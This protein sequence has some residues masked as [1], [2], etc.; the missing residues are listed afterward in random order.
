MTEKTESYLGRGLHSERW[1]KT[2]NNNGPLKD[3]IDEVRKDK[4]L[5]LQIRGDYFNVY[6]KGGNLVKV[7]SENSFEFDSNY[8]KGNPELVDSEI[9]R[10]DSRKKLLSWLKSKRDYHSF[11]DKMKGLMNSYWIWLKQEKGRD[12]HEKDI[13]HTLCISNTESTDFTIIDLE[14]QV[15][16]QKECPYCYKKLSIPLG[17]FVDEKKLSPR[18]DIIAV[19]NKDHRLCV[20]ELKS[21]IN[22]LYGKSGIG[23]HADSFEGSIGRN[24]QAFVKEMKGLVEN[25]KK[26]HL[27]GA[28]FHMS[29]DNPEFLYA[30]AYT[31]EDKTEKA[32]E[33]K[34]FENEQENSKSNHYRVIYLNKGDF[35]LHN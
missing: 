23:D 8:F 15:S 1:N 32:R 9:K 25:K 10:K 29:D 24:P 2:L 5:I 12:L 20:I 6:Y 33:R 3:F 26:L 22:A 21:G 35:T 18:F 17:R 16:I 13:Q 4:D 30:Y 31:S 28:D 27:L 19:R 34:A 14:F 11:I 7:N